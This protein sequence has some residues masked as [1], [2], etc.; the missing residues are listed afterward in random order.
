MSFAN[1]SGI[2]RVVVISDEIGAGGGA[3][4][5]AAQSIEQLLARGVRVAA[6]LG[7]EAAG[8]AA[9][10]GV[11]ILSLGGSKISETAGMGEALAGLYDARV[12]R[13]IGRWIAQ[14]DTPATVYH[15][16]N[17]HKLL[18][19]SVFQALRPVASRLV[20]NAHDYFLVCPNGA[21]FNFRSGEICALRPMSAQCAKSN[22]DKRRYAHKA[23]RLARQGV[24][25]VLFPLPASEA[26]VLAPH[27]GML[28]FLER[29]GVRRSSV[30]ILRNPVTPWRARRVEAEIQNRIFF[31]GRLER[32][33]G[34]DLLAEA[35]DRHAVSLSIIG[36]GPLLDP[37]RRRFQR[38]DFLG[39]KSRAELSEIAGSARLVVAP[40][41]WPET[42]CLTAFEAAT[43]GIPVLISQTALAASELTE[44]EAAEGFDP[45]DLDAV[46]A[47]L[48][49]LRDDS[50]RIEY[51]SRRGFAQRH[52]LALSAELWCEGL[53][54][55]YDELLA[56]AAR[57][58]SSC[59]GKARLAGCPGGIAASR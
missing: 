45:R 38:H 9:P 54:S 5:V 26:L 19:P 46:G 22:C 6:L 18:S 10:A 16:H 2:D 41:L 30:R 28:E 23:W 13:R 33:K 31:V 36:D 25:S 20:I 24:R 11:E 56:R 15:L 44:R 49:R 7:R 4:A 43:S 1:P 57:D 8:F 48:R 55:I 51:L 35:A 32:D 27:E 29:G 39:W 47:K 40:T 12:H 50:G 14:N 58:L 21:Y 17:W 59:G 52:D 42:F 34:V 3:A 53:I 37:L